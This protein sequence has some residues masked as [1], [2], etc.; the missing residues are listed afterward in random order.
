MIQPAIGLV[1]FMSIAKGIEACDAMLKKAQVELVEAHTICSGK[2]IVLITGD[3]DAVR[4]SVSRG[5]D[6]GGQTVVDTFLIPNVHPQVFMAL[7]GTANIDSLQA[8][9]VIETFSA[10]SCIVASDAAV[11]AAD[12]DLMEVRLANGMGGKSFV[13]LTGE[14]GSVEAAVKAGTAVIADDGMLVSQ[15]VIPRP[16]ETMTRVVF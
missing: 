1:E 16:H 4:S 2:Y 7:R 14:V 12:V 13:T 9:G 8:L 15:V 10:A 3:V 6:V 11:K 5:L